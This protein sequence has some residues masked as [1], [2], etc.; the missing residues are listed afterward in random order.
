MYTF[1]PEES[2]VDSHEKR[3]ERIERTMEFLVEHDA[4][5]SAKLDSLAVRVDEVAGRVDA[6]AGT[7]GTLTGTVG[8]LAGAV[9]RQQAEIG[10]IAVE[11]R[12]AI[13]R[14][15]DIAEGIADSVN[16]LGHHVVDHEARIRRLEGPAPPE[17][18]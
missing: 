4:A 7:V 13:S 3:F 1:S 8:T 14:M 2:D 11:C 16:S 6:L 12:D 15:I 17:V 9:E 5:L 10:E 18:A